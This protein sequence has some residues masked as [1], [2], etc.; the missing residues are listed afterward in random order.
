MDKQPENEPE[1]IQ[2][3]TSRDMLRRIS[4]GAFFLGLTGVGITTTITL[5]APNSINPNTFCIP[6]SLLSVGGIG[7]F[8]I[9]LMP[10]YHYKEMRRK[11]PSDQTQGYNNSDNAGDDLMR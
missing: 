2:K 1:Q 7:G 3:L 11:V 5:V 10:D 6:F 4:L 9:S 8:L